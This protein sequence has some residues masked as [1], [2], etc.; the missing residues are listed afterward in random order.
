MQECRRIN[1][2]S[3]NRNDVISLSLILFTFWMIIR[4]AAVTFNRQILA[5]T[6][7]GYDFVAYHNYARR[8][9]NEMPQG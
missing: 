7:Q 5:D 2:S 8:R 4:I 6:A 1:N 3:S 9:Y